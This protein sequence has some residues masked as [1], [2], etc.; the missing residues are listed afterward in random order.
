MSKTSLYSVVYPPM[1][2]SLQALSGLLDIAK[3]HADKHKTARLDFESALLHD[4]IIFDQFPLIRQ[5]QIATD[6]AKN[7]IH[8]LTGKEV[9]KFED[10]ETTFEELK[11]RIQKT[12]T[13]VRSVQESDFA[14]SEDVRVSLPY[15]D[16]KSLSGFEY[17]TMYL[18]PNF[19]FH[20]TTAYEILRKNGIKIG[21]SDFTGE[22]P[23][24]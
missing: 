5:V 18:M 7:S 16:G 9:P 11:E 24:V 6:Q 20:A 23:L 15:W 2:R 10:T 17:V 22:L 3:A 14:Q 13:L 8:R 19:Y 12:I 4:R 21:K 1:L